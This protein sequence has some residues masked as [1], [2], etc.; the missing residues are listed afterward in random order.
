MERHGDSGLM[1]TEQEE[2][3]NR[4]ATGDSAQIAEIVQQVLGRLTTS[5]DNASTA[6]NL[7]K[8]DKQPATAT[9]STQK[10]I[11]AQTIQ[12]LSGQP[13]QVFVSPTAVITPAA[14][15]EARHRK[16]TI[17]RTVQ[18]SPEQRPDHQRLEIIDYAQ[19]ERA[20]AVRQQLAIRGVTTGTA[21]IVL[22]DTPAREVHFQC[23]KNNETA[24]MIGAYSDIR[25]FSDELSPTL[26]VLDMKRLNL[27]AAVNA[28]VHITSTRN[29]DR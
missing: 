13:A 28:V 15:D 4:V 18:L 20:E 3:S 26:W 16:I 11:T 17:Q 6:H 5:H 10:I 8:T 9:A 14:R 23:A 12:E 25:R 21:K 29:T 22:T 1:T 24:V 27:S 19:P 7:E 2:D